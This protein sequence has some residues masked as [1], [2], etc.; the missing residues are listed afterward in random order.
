MVSDDLRDL[1]KILQL[2]GFGM[3]CSVAVQES[4]VINT[5]C[6]MWNMQSDKGTL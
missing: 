1:D 3:V 2:Q 4:L 6:I 5:S